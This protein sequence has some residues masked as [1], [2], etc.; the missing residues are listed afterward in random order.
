MSAQE[1]GEIRMLLHV[2]LARSML[3]RVEKDLA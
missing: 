3:S 1:R 2:H